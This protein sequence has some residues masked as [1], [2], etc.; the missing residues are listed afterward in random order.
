ML[1]RNRCVSLILVSPRPVLEYVYFS[2]E[3][4]LVSTRE[5]FKH[6]STS[7]DRRQGRLDRVEHPCLHPI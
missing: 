5:Q 3:Q 1:V 2:V 4:K 6:L 7:G